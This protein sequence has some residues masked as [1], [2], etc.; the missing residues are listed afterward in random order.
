MATVTAS[1]DGA[2]KAVTY[3][4][5]TP[6]TQLLW[7]E[8]SIP[9]TFT[10]CSVTRYTGGVRGRIL[11]CN[12]PS[13]S[14]DVLFGHWM[15]A[16][17]LAYFEAWM[18]SQASIGVVDDWLVM[19]GTNDAAVP[20]PGNQIV[21]QDEIGIL[22]GG[23]TQCRLNV[24]YYEPSDWALHSVLI[25]DYSIGAAPKPCHSIPCQSLRRVPSRLVLTRLSLW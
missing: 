1:G 22:N 12:S 15:G 9:A 7:P 3:I 18:T 11:N 17:G 25:W 21:D 6:S 14:R 2:A 8:W 23:V 24:G 4:R 20:V 16:R 19:C 5:G 10:I 13:Q